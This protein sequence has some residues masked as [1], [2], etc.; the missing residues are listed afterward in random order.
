MYGPDTHKFWLGRTGLGKTTAQNILRVSILPQ[1]TS[2]LKKIIEF[3][4]Q[5]VENGG[6]IPGV[7]T[8]KIN[9]N[10][11]HFGIFSVNPAEYMR[12]IRLEENF[13]ATDIIA[14][15]WNPKT[16]CKVKRTPA[17]VYRVYFY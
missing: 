8:R 5:R 10:E 16:F 3:A 2:N 6:E 9:W 14:S 13:S 4:S 15:Q 7:S 17:P 11:Q 12:E 1:V